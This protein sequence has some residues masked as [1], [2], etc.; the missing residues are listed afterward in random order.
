MCAVGPVYGCLLLVVGVLAGAE[1][2]TAVSACVG[3]VIGTLCVLSTEKVR[4]EAILRTRRR[5]TQRMVGWLLF[6]LLILRWC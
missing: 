6:V 4:G 1:R 5:L 2:L 3:C